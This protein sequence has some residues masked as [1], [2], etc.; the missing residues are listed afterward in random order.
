LPS[1]GKTVGRHFPITVY[2]VLL[3]MRR[4][5]DSK[6]PLRPIHTYHAVPML[7]TCRSRAMPRICLSES[8]LL[9]PWQGRG[10]VAAG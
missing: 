7:F 5:V 1:S 4:G 10:R 3:N 8:D 6:I 9:R 2:C